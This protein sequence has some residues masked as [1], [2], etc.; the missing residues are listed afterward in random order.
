MRMKSKTT[1]L[2]TT[3]LLL[4]IAACG[5]DDGT[6]LGTQVDGGG[7]E[8]GSGKD[9]GDGKDA[10]D[11]K[12]A[13]DASDAKDSGDGEAG[14]DPIK[15]I[16]LKVED[17]IGAQQP[18][19]PSSYGFASSANPYGGTGTSWRYQKPMTG[20]SD[21]KLELHLPFDAAD[22]N[23]FT[24][25]ADHLGTVTI[26]DI[27]SIKVR[28]RRNDAV[29][30]DFMVLLYT[31]PHADVSKNDAPWYARRLHAHLSWAK[32]LNAP[33][34]TWNT[35]STA[36][37]TNQ[38]NFWDF[39]NKDTNVGPQ[40]N[41]NYFTLADIQN[42]PVT[43][44]GVTGARDYRTEKVRFLTISTTSDNTTFD[45][46][47]DGIE[48]VLKNGKGVSIDLAGDANLRRVSVSQSRMQD[49]DPPDTNS[50]YGAVSKDGP[51]GNA[52][53]SWRF[54]KDGNGA[55]K[56]ELYLTFGAK[57]EDA[58]TAIWK[59]VREHL[60]P[61]TIE[62]IDSIGVRSK[63]IAPAT[64]DFTM[65]VYTLPDG[66]KDDASWY[67]RRLH[68]Q[69]DWSAG[70]NAPAGQWNTFSTKAGANQ[71]RFWD[72]RPDNVA[73][74]TQFTLAEMQA[75]PIT[76]AG[77]SARDY[78]TEKV[79]YISFST[80]SNYTSFDGA[81]DGFEVRLKNGKQLVVDL[82]K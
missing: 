7:A 46:S 20:A 32:S 64:N 8:T 4:A 29:T 23:G 67:S 27:Q 72:F 17:V 52:G 69:F 47:I 28:S 22:A 60:G 3:G 74:G 66:D 82:D 25:I 37:G 11:P 39:R 24:D 73:L 49:V 55:E 78:R 14:G 30:P 65:I 77:L 42:G 40:P 35:F 26:A 38:L 70:L 45:G 1:V 44:A 79:R 10:G 48:V 53:S 76:P 59:S 31:Q 6:D 81:I 68:A 2:L 16:T 80:Y 63:K 36:A 34:E 18:V 54:T 71:L 62:N 21:E 5:D 57:D 9:S 15:K 19:G 58:K 43:P 61:F 41:A 56:F 12:D 50:S 51:W 75:G 33:H 13:S